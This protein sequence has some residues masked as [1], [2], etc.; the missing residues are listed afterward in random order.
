MADGTSYS[1]DEVE[2]ILRRAAEL[3][4][5]QPLPGDSRSMS[6]AEIESVAV[7][8]GLSQALVRRAATEIARPA[9]PEQSSNGWL[10]GPTRLVVERIIEGEYPIEEFDHLLEIIRFGSMGPGQISSVGRSLTWQGALSASQAPPTSALSF[11]HQRTSST[12]YNTNV[13]RLI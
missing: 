3:Q 10:G 1:E 12:S 11:T 13:H 5:Q 9:E 6:L 2:L 8:A 4:K 7:E